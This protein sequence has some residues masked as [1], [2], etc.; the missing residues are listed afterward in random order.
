MKIL[1]TLVRTTDRGMAYVDTIEFEGRLWLAPEWTVGQ[2]PEWQIPV[3]IV[4]L[5]GLPRTKNETPLPADFLLTNPIPK[6]VLD[7]T[8]PPEKAIGFV[9]EPGPNT[10]RKPS[11]TVH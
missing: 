10:L 11:D 8:I 1:K 9:V 4:L 5:D 6:G 7:G 2:S 3:R